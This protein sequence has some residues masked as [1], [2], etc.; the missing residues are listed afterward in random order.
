VI[1]FLPNAVVC[2]RFGDKIRSLY[3]HKP[4][5]T[6]HGLISLLSELRYNDTSKAFYT[7][8]RQE[9]DAIKVEREPDL[10]RHKDPFFIVPI[11]VNRFF[12][13]SA[14]RILRDSVPETITDLLIRIVVTTGDGPSLS[15]PDL[16]AVLD[17]GLHDVLYFD[18]QKCDEYVNEEPI[19]ED[20]RK[21]GLVLV[22]QTD[23][24]MSVSFDVQG[25]VRPRPSSPQPAD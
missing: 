10:K 16:K 14:L 11:V 20:H 15:I 25:T 3:N 13:E 24:G 21:Q 18:W 6:H 8:V 7:R 1:V 17:T 2:R 5:Q 9:I 12:T 4:L 19:P 22:G 23:F